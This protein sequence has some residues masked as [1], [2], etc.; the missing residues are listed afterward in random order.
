MPCVVL[1]CLHSLQ[2]VSALSDETNP[3]KLFFLDKIEPLKLI[4]SWLDGDVSMPEILADGGFTKTFRQQREL[5]ATLAQTL[6]EIYLNFVEP[7]PN[8][9]PNSLFNET[10][11]GPIQSNWN[12]LYEVDGRFKGRYI[13]Q[14]SCAI[15]KPKATAIR[16]KMH[17]DQDIYR[18]NDACD[19]MK[20]NAEEFKDTGL[21]FQYASTVSGVTMDFPASIRG[22]SYDNRY[23]TWFRK[24]ISPPKDVVI[25]VDHSGS[26][27][28]SAPCGALKMAEAQVISIFRSFLTDQDRVQLMLMGDDPQ[29]SPCFGRRLVPGD[30]QNLK[31][32]L[33]WFYAKSRER[34]GQGTLGSGVIEALSLLDAATKDG[35][36]T[37][38][39][40]FI[41]VITDGLEIEDIVEMGLRRYATD[42]GTTLPLPGLHVVGVLLNH[43]Q[44]H[45]RATTPLDAAAC[46]QVPTSPCM[47]IL[48]S[49]HWDLTL[50]Q[51]CSAA[52]SGSSFCHLIPWTGLQ[53]PFKKLISRSMMAKY[54]SKPTPCSC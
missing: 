31:Q 43:H 29:L 1:Y 49:W 30:D 39:A 7:D 41:M 10:N 12:A 14:D 11:V 2:V 46:A 5:V 48:H 52:S 20:T 36:S 24:A 8:F 6:E 35:D 37:G 28:A 23:E 47:R 13:K 45:I 15:H 42:T 3:T 53:V 22:M 17:I 27:E 9:S 16:D 38:G 33:G 34:G 44:N 40:R 32:L 19:Q 54:L 4:S 25:V 21:T 26:M 51:N 18:V 50:F